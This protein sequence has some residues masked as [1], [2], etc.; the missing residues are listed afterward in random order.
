MGPI[1][2]DTYAVILPEQYSDL[3][4]LANARRAVRA[5]RALLHLNT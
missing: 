4:A 2:P 5:L 3:H 1:Q